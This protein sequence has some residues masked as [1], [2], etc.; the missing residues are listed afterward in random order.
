MFTTSKPLDLE[1]NLSKTITKILNIMSKRKVTQKVM[2]AIMMVALAA[3]IAMSVVG[4]QDPQGQGGTDPQ[5]FLTV[6]TETL[7]FEAVPSG[8]QSVEFTS[9][10]DVAATTDADWCTVSVK[11]AELQVTAQKNE[12]DE[13]RSCVISIQ[14]ADGL[15]EIID[16]TQ[17]G[18]EP[19]LLLSADSVSFG[20][21]SESAEVTVTSN[22]AWSAA[23]EAEWI[24]VE[25]T[26]GKVT[27]TAE[28]NTAE[29][30]EAVVTITPTVEAL[31]EYAKS[32][33]VSQAAFQ[34]TL[35]LES[36][37]IT[38][39]AIEISAEGGRVAAN[40]TTNA[41]WTA[42]CEADWVTLS[43]NSGS[44]ADA[45]YFTFR[46]AENTTLVARSTEVKF[47]C[48]N[49]E[50]VISISQAA[51]GLYAEMDEAQKQ[52]TFADIAATQTIAISTNGYIS[53][54]SSA[55]DW[56]TVAVEE[57]S[58]V[59]VSAATNEGDAREATITITINSDPLEPTVDP[60]VITIAVSQKA[61]RVA[62]D[63]SAAGTANTYIVNQAGSYY[64]FNGSVRGNGKA[65]NLQWKSNDAKDITVNWGYDEAYVNIAPAKAI[66]V[67][68]NAS[69][70]GE[71]WVKSSPVVL[72]SVMLGADGYVYFETPE[73]FING[74]VMLAVTDANDE[75]LWSWNIWACEGF[76]PDATAKTVGDVVIMD[77]NLGAMIGLEAKDESDPVKAA[78]AIGNYY[79]WGR[80]DP[81]PTASE[82]GKADNA[83][84][85]S[86]KWGLPTYTPLENLKHDLSKY[87]WGTDNVLYT[88]TTANNSI[89]LKTALGEGFTIEQ[90]IAQTVKTPYLWA[91]N[92]TGTGNE[93]P[94]MWMVSNPLDDTKQ[95]TWRA[96]WG[97]MNCVDGV[98]TVYDPCPAGW[99]VADAAAI[100]LALSKSECC[101]NGYGVYSAEWDVY[102]P[103]GG[104]RASIY[105][106]VGELP[107]SGS[108]K[109]LYLATSTV[110]T[111]ANPFRGTRTI[112][113]KNGP[114]DY[115]DRSAAAS[116][117]TS[118]SY[119]GAAVP[120][121]CVKEEK[122]TPATPA[123]PT[124]PKAA[125]LGDSITEVWE[126]R[127]SNP[128]FFKS[129]DYVHQGQSGTMTSNF[130]SR[131]NWVRVKDPKVTVICGGIN[132]LAE[133]G[134]YWVPLEDTY[135]NIRMIARMAE[136]SGSQV[137][138]GATPPA[139]TIWWN[140]AAWNAAH[141]DI[142]ERVVQLNAKLK[143][144]AEECGY[145]YCDFHTALKDD[146]NG[147]ALEYS[148]TSSDRVHPN[149]AG[150]A[151]ME[152][153]VKPI[154]DNLLG[155]SDDGSIGF[156]GNTPNVD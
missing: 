25:Q 48:G 9:S 122:V 62:T 26:A 102:F 141:S 74:N 92:S 17:L 150:Y 31:A 30:R 155:L 103:F 21:E 108:K 68:Y 110:S 86:M 23:C 54:T 104:Q 16:V 37:G 8:A 28:D 125:F 67:W 33:T 50:L 22:I 20:Y 82:Y 66:T 119:V 80:K 36:D 41:D 43:N 94:Y 118:N 38:E 57:N 88:S 127:T 139:N 132:D 131:Y 146:Q 85:G 39:N 123:E 140:D 49:T 7:N 128:D 83:L 46:I 32:F 2:A 44:A 100:G 4:C 156:G 79:Q 95:V 15:T 133:N 34:N 40:L 61:K 76:N 101:T 13:S 147:L 99:M 3:F 93:S 72:E 42:E 18:I 19:E 97:N 52:L 109:N 63:L 60:T 90:A 107:M 89:G 136:L 138:I 51:A 27:I 129:N 5:P 96:L 11:T 124:G 113:S 145:T 81:I 120:L 154:I 53:A 134:D 12:L 116:I 111:N 45:K 152:S 151:V 112:D 106:N 35:I 55:T 149:G 148:W 78:W 10:S 126:A 121:R 137:V 71:E 91:S 58:K 87:P 65:L 29:A 69:K 70:A 117:T 1:F 77:R 144:M 115:S 135:N 98:K 142:G 105:S 114:V 56:L 130:A 64:K 84:H 47:T 14:N 75:I 59:V 153:I 24:E 73:K 6:S 143:A